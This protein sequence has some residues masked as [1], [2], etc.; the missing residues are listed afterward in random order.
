V[1]NLVDNA[2]RHGR[3]DDGRV[4]LTLSVTSASDGALVFR[5]S[6]EGRG[7]GG[8]AE[9]LFEP[10]ARGG[11]DGEAPGTGLGLAIVRA[12]AVG[13][14]GRARALPSTSGACLEL[15]IPLRAPEGGSL[16]DVT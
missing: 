7:L 9:T 12:I 3:G 13:H 10:F 14:G 4:V 16:E 2:L 5:V 8:R 6:D 15:D 11:R 1:L